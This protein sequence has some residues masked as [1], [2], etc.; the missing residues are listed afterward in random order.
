MPDGWIAFS[1]GCRCCDG[2]NEYACGNCPSPWPDA[3]ESIDAYGIQLSP[4]TWGPRAIHFVNTAGFAY[5][6]SYTVTVG[7]NTWT[8]TYTIL[9]DG[10]NI[11][12]TK[13]LKLGLQTYYEGTSTS[14]EIDCDAKT[15]VFHMP[16]YD[17]PPGWGDAP[18]HDVEVGP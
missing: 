7:L 5:L 2:L 16:A 13:T 14:F 1:P 12:L 15:I 18:A 6:G 3:I 17:A 11:V 10:N 9:C 4:P 8:G